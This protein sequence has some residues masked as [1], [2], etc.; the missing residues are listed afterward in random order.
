[1]KLGKTGKMWW[2]VICTTLVIGSISTGK[3]GQAMT[4]EKKRDEP[5]PFS[6]FSDIEKLQ[7]KLASEFPIGMSWRTIAE[8]LVS[9]GVSCGPVEPYVKLVLPAGVTMSESAKRSEDIKEFRVR[10]STSPSWLPTR[11]FQGVTIDAELDKEQRLLL[12]V[13]T[14]YY[15]KS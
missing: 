14:P 7:K 4:S 6:S 8:R 10:C 11:S 15:K 9:S 1:M 13:A 12:I 3:E 2:L 5:I